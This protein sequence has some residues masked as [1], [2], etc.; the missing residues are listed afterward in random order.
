MAPSA[1]PQLKVPEPPLFCS[2]CCCSSQ[3]LQFWPY[4]QITAL[5]EGTKFFHHTHTHSSLLF[6]A[7]CA[8]DL[9][10]V[11]PSRSPTLVTLFRPPIRAIDNGEGR[12]CEWSSTLSQNVMNFCLQTP[13]MEPSF[14]GD[15][16]RETFLPGVLNARR[17]VKQSDVVDLSVQDSASGTITNRKWHVGNSLV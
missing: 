12:V 10:T 7:I 11:Q 6:H 8:C 2:C 14:Y 17:T 15:R 9:I 1:P 5:G 13:K 4:S 3:V 16:L